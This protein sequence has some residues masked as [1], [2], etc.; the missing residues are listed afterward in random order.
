MEINAI[1]EIIAEATYDMRCYMRAIAREVA[2]EM[3]WD[4][5]L[6]MGQ[7]TKFAD[8]LLALRDTRFP[9]TGKAPHASE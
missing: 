4:R 6:A 9:P 7:G 8:E 3:A 5:F 2:R 1:R